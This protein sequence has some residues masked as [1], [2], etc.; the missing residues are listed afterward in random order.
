MLRLAALALLIAPAAALAQ[1]D[2]ASLPVNATEDVA[3]DRVNGGLDGAGTANWLANPLYIVDY[4]VRSFGDSALDAPFMSIVRQDDFP[5][6][7]TQTTFTILLDGFL[8]DSLRGERYEI[9]LVPLEMD[10]P[11]QGT[12][13]T[14]SW[15]LQSANK[16]WR[17]R[18]GRGESEAYHT[19]P[20]S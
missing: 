18:A 5:D 15:R 20:C 8:D 7:P 6:G 16:S 1:S 11:L 4:A 9:V 2:P 10:E 17:C 12:E 14:R 3:V 19:T 13:T